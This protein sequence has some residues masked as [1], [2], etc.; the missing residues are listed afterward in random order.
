MN[1]ISPEIVEKT[2]KKM[3][4]QSPETAS[5]MIEQHKIDSVAFPAISTGAFG[6]P[7]K[8]AAEIALRTVVEMLPKLQHVK[9]ISMPGLSTRLCRVTIWLKMAKIHPPMAKQLK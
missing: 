3:G 7:V 9:R 5:M 4:S 6:Y 8:E 1:S 2:W